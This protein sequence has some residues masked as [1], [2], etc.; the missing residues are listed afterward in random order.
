M[1]VPTASAARYTS[2]PQRFAIDAR[3]FVNCE[4]ALKAAA[5]ATVAV[6]DSGTHDSWFPYVLPAGSVAS[7]RALFSGNIAEL[8][9]K[10]EA[11]GASLWENMS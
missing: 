4:N 8:A 5:E 2:G 6:F 11:K 3:G 1:F 10:C 9:R 7:S